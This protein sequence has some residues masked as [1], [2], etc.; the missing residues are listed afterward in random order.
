MKYPQLDPTIFIKNRKRFTEKMEPGS[1]AIFHSNHVYSKNGDAYHRFKQNSDLFWLSGIDQENTVLVLFP[2]CPIESYKECLFITE[3]N[4]HIAKWDGYKYTKNHA[5]ETSGISNI[6][7]NNNYFNQLRS[8]INLAENIYLP[9]NENDRFI[10]KSSYQNL[11]FAHHVKHEFPLHNYK[12]SGNIIQR[13]RSIKTEE[14]LAVH[15]QGLAIHKKAFER[16][17]KFTKPGVGEYEIE[18]ELIHEFLSN[19]ATNFSFD[20]I[21]A[22]GSAACTLHYIDNNKICKDGELLLLDTG[23]DYANFSTDMTRCFPVNGRFTPRQKDVYNSV[24]F[25]MRE[26]N[27]ILKPGVMLM[28]YHKEVGKLMEEQLL[29]L[30][31]LTQK[32]I[33]QQGSDENQK[34]YKKYFMHGTS[35][36]LGIDVHDSGL[37]YEPL[38]EN[39]LLTVEPGIYIDEEGIGVR[40]EN[41]VILKSSGNIDLM[42]EINMPIEVEEIE[43]IMNR[44]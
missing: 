6:Y 42:D 32:D 43:E 31:L 4:A 37:R 1:I 12:R 36:F 41:N 18:A 5:T 24:L 17:L 27:K 7:W 39:A 15:R 25:V 21:V 29:K 19:R 9:L 23:V 13:L 8:I 14:E 35:H 28:E 26:A 44:Q 22:S 20:P 2:D 34:A 3:T 33:A 11:D 10:P 38:P 40:I 16:V 30:G